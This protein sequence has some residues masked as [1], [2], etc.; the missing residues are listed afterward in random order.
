MAE[1]E[2]LELSLVWNL[3]KVWQVRSGY[4][5]LDARKEDGSRLAR[6]PRHT[7]SV[8]IDYKGEK[9]IG[10][11]ELLSVSDRMD[12]GLAKGEDYVVA[13]LYGSYELSSFLSLFGR[14]ENLF[15]EEYEEVDGYPTL[16][17]GAFGVLRYSF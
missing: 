11:A 1:M 3:T 5:Y 13:R 10:G 15:D 12:F 4:T 7:P 16:G 6:R 2:G 17:V 9:V 14:V 8:A